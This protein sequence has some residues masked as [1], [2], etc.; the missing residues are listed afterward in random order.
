MKIFVV[1]SKNKP[2]PFEINEFDTVKDLKDKIKKKMGINKD[3]L[4]HMNG[5][6]FE[7]KEKLEEYEIEE[8]S[9][10]TCTIQF[11]GGRFM[12]IINYLHFYSF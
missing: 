5:A 6:I 12:N 2:I 4:L 8:N 1:D 3:I 11:R 9:Y 10:I 7:D